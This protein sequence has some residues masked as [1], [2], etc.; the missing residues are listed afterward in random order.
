MTQNIDGHKLES[1]RT[2]GKI[3]KNAIEFGKTLIKK[4]KKVNF[5]VEEIE[6]YIKRHAKLAFP[7]NLSFNA[8]AAHDTS[9]FND[10][11]IIEGNEVIKLDVGTN[12]DGYIADSAVTIDLSGK[13]S[14]LVKASEE[15]LSNALKLCIPGTK[16]SEI[17]E[18]I[19]NTIESYGFTPITN[20]SGHYI[21]RNL[22][23]TGISIP[24]IKTNNNHILEKGD[25]IAIE[26]FATNGN[27]RVYESGSPKIF[28]LI[29]STPQRLPDAKLLLTKIESN[30]G[31]LPFSYNHLFKL[32]GI[33]PKKIPMAFSFLK[34]SKIFEEYPPLVEINK[35]IV[36]QA[37]HTVIVMDKPIV[38]T[39]DL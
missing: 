22:L 25:V 29:K 20:L 4:G 2:A 39:R 27:G 28:M 14:N 36:T 12:V 1:L 37:E 19:Q 32:D 18:S 9:D 5:I 23:H 3:N 13:Y 34:R 17:S 10:E 8:C 21:E 24:N 16:I 35:G 15:A 26:P 30:F 31:S 7:V 11:R 6:S 33:D 38:T